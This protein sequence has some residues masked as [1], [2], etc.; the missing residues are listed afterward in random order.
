MKAP[1]VG[2]NLFAVSRRP[3]PDQRRVLAYLVL[4]RDRNIN[5]YYPAGQNIVRAQIAPTS[6]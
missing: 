4:P 1:P 3:A 2:V 6:E 5:D